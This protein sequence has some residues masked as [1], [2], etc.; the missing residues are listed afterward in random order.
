MK[1]EELEKAILHSDL[2]D[3]IKLELIR[4]VEQA[5]NDKNNYDFYWEH[6]HPKE[7]Y[8]ENPIKIIKDRKIDFTGPTC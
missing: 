6:S 5:K 3:E 4:C 2:N 7:I 8:P 1:K